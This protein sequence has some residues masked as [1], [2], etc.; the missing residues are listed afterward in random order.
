VGTVRQPTGNPDQFHQELAP[1]PAIPTVGAQQP[2]GAGSWNG[3]DSIVLT[4][5]GSGTVPVL[6][7]LSRRGQTPAHQLGT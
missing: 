7:E 1:D 2:T 4:S 6:T 3:N 5:D